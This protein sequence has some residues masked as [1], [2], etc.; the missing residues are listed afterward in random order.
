[1]A[2]SAGC[3]VLGLKMPRPI[4][5]LLVALAINV[6]LTIAL[7]EWYPSDSQKLWKPK[8]SASFASSRVSPMDVVPSAPTPKL[9]KLLTAI[10]CVRF[11]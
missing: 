8:A 4:L 7:L 1:M 9:S 10:F 3:L 2:N 5:I 6:A 11:A